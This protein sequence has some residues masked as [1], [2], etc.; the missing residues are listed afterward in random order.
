MPKDTCENAY[1]DRFSIK[2]RSLKAAERL[3]GAE[4]F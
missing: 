2:T 4:F 1:L 3:K